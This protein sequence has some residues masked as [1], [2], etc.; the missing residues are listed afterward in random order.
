MD[1]ELLMWLT[2]IGLDADDGDVDGGIGLA[3]SSDGITWTADTGNPIASVRRG[4]MDFTAQ[5]SVVVLP[6][7]GNQEVPA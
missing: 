7:S 5:P 3:R 4:P 6:E 2:V 1:G